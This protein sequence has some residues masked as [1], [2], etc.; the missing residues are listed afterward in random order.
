MGRSFAEAIVARRAIRAQAW[1]LRENQIKDWSIAYRAC[2]MVSAGTLQ[3]I[4]EVSK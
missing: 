3:L 1:S 2:E 4:W